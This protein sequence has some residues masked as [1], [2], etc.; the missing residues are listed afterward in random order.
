[1]NYELIKETRLYKVANTDPWVISRLK[2]ANGEYLI[3]LRPSS[4][5][6]E[7]VILQ[8]WE[9]TDYENVISLMVSVINPVD[10]EVKE[11]PQCGR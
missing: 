9:D 7:I 8:E 11:G 2:S 4:Q 5:E 1:M 10:I 6:N 3:S